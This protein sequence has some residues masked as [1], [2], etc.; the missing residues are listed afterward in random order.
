MCPTIHATFRWSSDFIRSVLNMLP[1]PSAALI[2]FQLS[3]Y[4]TLLMDSP[5][6]IAQY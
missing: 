2:S 5:R 4:T 3:G 1:P 6:V